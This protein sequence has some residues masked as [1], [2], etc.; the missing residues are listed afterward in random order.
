VSAG[1]ESFRTPAPQ[2][3]IFDLDDTILD[4]SGAMEA[5]WEEV[6]ADAAGRLDG[7]GAVALRAAIDRRRDVYWADPDRHR[8]GRMDLRTA[9]RLI[10]S[11]AL[12]D[13]GIAVEEA[14][15]AIAGTYRD[16]R[17]AR[18][19][20]FPGAIETLERA[21]ARGI[22]LGLITNGSATGQRSKVERFRLAGYFDH[23]LIEGEFGAGKPDRTVYETTLRALAASPEL[24]WSVGDN[25]EWDVA[26]PQELGIHGIWVDALRK[27]LP[28]GTPVRPDRTIRSISELVQ[29]V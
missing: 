4:D 19:R 22:R 25:L 26:A 10:V 24:T 29:E 1:S 15:Q 23:V 9:T 18:Q 13:L 14:A 21:R 17:E 12:E 20:V 8:E 27:G 6:C 2:A 11:Q 3:I 7:V 16:L 28:K 5:C